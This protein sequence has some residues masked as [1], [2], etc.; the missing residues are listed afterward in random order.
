MP[1]CTTVSRCLVKESFFKVSVSLKRFSS[2]II[3]S[4]RNYLILAFRYFNI[5][6]FR[7]CLF[8]HNYYSPD[9]NHSLL[10]SIDFHTKFE[11]F[12]QKHIFQFLSAKKKKNTPGG[13]YM[14]YFW[15][16]VLSETVLWSL[17]F[18]CRIRRGPRE[19]YEVEGEEVPLQRFE[20]ALN[21][22]QARLVDSSC[23]K[24]TP[25]GGATTDLGVDV[26]SRCVTTRIERPCNRDLTLVDLP[27]K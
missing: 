25:G 8:K 1:Y 3:F 13:T 21:Y 17:F 24:L 2:E 19:C 18:F 4:M 15:N 16:S 6:F 9:H 7:T 14:C 11:N 12:T 10:N 26:T 5:L 22:A 27:G 20:S 23:P